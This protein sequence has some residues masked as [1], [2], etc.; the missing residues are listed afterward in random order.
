M[1]GSF[2]KRLNLLFCVIS[3]SLCEDPLADFVARLRAQARPEHIL[4]LVDKL[5]ADAHNPPLR[6]GT[7]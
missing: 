4:R 2:L 3:D 6:V 1:H 5:D 7:L